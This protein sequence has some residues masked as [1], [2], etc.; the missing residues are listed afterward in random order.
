MLPATG[1]TPG[2]KPGRN[3]AFR[4]HGDGHGSSKRPSWRRSGRGTA[5]GRAAGRSGR[6]FRDRGAE[7][8]APSPGAVQVRGRGERCPDHGEFV[9]NLVAAA[10]RWPRSVRRPRGGRKPVASR[11]DRAT[12]R[13]AVG[14][15]LGRVGCVPGP[16]PPHPCPRHLPRGGRGNPPRLVHGPVFLHLGGGLGS[17]ASEATTSLVTAAVHA[18]SDAPRRRARARGRGRRRTAAV[19]ARTARSPRPAG[20]GPRPAPPGGG[21]TPGQ[22]GRPRPGRRGPPGGRRGA[23]RVWPPPGRRLPPR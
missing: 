11:G 6:P 13:E 1:R 23:G 5:P 22:P 8:G 20:D 17:F 12:S 19:R 21:T 16:H 9:R 14:P 2:R 15:A 3:R 7:P 4:A 10:R 18:L